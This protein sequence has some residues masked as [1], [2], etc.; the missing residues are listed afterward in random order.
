MASSLS[1]S[2]LTRGKTK[3][4]SVHPGLRRFFHLS[5]RTLAD[6]RGTVRV[7]VDFLRIEF[8]PLGPD[9]SALLPSHRNTDRIPHD[10]V[11]QPFKPLGRLCM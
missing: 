2:R 10:R 11:S 8:Q 1:P 6:Y 4:Q 5:R 3:L 7:F 9:L